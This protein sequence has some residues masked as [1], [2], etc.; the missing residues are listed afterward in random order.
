MNSWLKKFLLLILF[1]TTVGVWLIRDV[2]QW[3]IGFYSHIKK[4]PEAFSGNCSILILSP[5]ELVEAHSAAPFIAFYNSECLSTI[6][7]LT[8][9]EQNI[10][11]FIL[12]PVVMQKGTVTLLKQFPKPLN[13]DWWQNLTRILPHQII[14]K[15]HGVN[16]MQTY[17][18]TPIKN[19]SCH[20]T[21]C[22]VAI[23]PYAKR[24]KSA[25]SCDQYTEFKLKTGE[26]FFANSS[27]NS[28]QAMNLSVDILGSNLENLYSIHLKQIREKA[29]VKC[30]LQLGLTCF[31][32]AAIL[33][34]KY[35]T[36]TCLLITEEYLQN[37][38]EKIKGE[39]NGVSKPAHL[40]YKLAKQNHFKL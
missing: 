29:L 32:L 17:V 38:R 1:V 7:D 14:A 21:N 20:K 15:W 22:I 25:S 9:A 12:D 35:A 4:Y 31:R 39:A 8:L 27:V 23:S 16:P 2:Y 37:I 33:S 5:S 40:Y 34:Q 36:R 10:S 13:L 18:A 6:E 28:A 11:S 3:E 24:A 26:F 30:E 19:D